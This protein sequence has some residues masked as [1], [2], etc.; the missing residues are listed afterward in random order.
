MQ[1]VSNQPS[2]ATSGPPLV[3]P[4]SKRSKATLTIDACL[5]SFISFTNGFNKENIS[6]EV[7]VAEVVE[8]VE[9]VEIAELVEVGE[10]DG[11]SVVVDEGGK[12]EGDN[13]TEDTDDPLLL[14]LL[15][16][17]VRCSNCIEHSLT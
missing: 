11:E 15:C 5:A 3:K 4:V 8:V 6:S 9:V 13:D 17:V 16:T 12:E 14:L 7:D 10:A 1:D 2:S